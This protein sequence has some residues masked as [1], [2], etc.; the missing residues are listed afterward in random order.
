[1]NW[2]PD[3]VLV[4]GLAFQ[5]VE[6]VPTPSHLEI[7]HCAQRIVCAEQNDQGFDAIAV[8]AVDIALLT[9]CS[10]LSKRRQIVP[11]EIHLGIVVS[12]QGPPFVRRLDDL[13][14][15]LVLRLFDPVVTVISRAR[16]SVA[17]VP[18][19][20]GEVVIK[21]EGLGNMRPRSALPPIFHFSHKVT[22][23][24]DGQGKFPPIDLR[25]ILLFKHSYQKFEIDRQTA[26][27]L[28]FR[29]AKIREPTHLVSN[30]GGVGNTGVEDRPA[31]KP[32]RQGI[33]NR[34]QAVFWLRLFR[35]LYLDSE[36][37]VKN[38]NARFFCDNDVIG[39]VGSQSIRLIVKQAVGLQ[40]GIEAIEN[41][42]LWKSWFFGHKPSGGRQSGKERR[43]YSRSSLTS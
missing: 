12:P 4:F 28:V 13:F 30:D 36:R 8:A 34:H 2:P 6:A 25:S 1:M 32:M 29:V 14:K 11:L 24:E 17:N 33:A 27:P 15:E 22:S 38:W 41:R 19:K 21:I 26:M 31:L 5:I 7:Q 37:R 20:N 10:C 9:Q 18:T 40:T 23:A 39:C 16:E 35:E 42:V 3:V 43:Q